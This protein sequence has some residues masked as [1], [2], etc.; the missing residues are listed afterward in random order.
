MD[1]N[2]NKFQEIEEDQPMSSQR[3]GHDLVTEQSQQHLRVSHQGKAGSK[4]KTQKVVPGLGT[5]EA[6]LSL[7]GA[8]SF[9]FS[10]FCL[11]S[12][13]PF[14]I[15]AKFVLIGIFIMAGIGQAAARAGVCEHCVKEGGGWECGYSAL[16]CKRRHTVYNCLPLPTR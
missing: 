10:F 8:F 14:L 15:G 12:S 9:I 4:K 13:T 16:L 7:L 5:V 1:M 2:L 6:E 11:L 3:V